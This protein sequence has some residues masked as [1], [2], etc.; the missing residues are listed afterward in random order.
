MLRS[1]FPITIRRLGFSASSCA[2]GRCGSDCITTGISL[3]H[4]FS[5]LAGQRVGAFGTFLFLRFLSVFIILFRSTVSI[6]T[7]RRFRLQA[8]TFLSFRHN[9]FRFYSP[10][11]IGRS[12]GWWFQ[13]QRAFVQIYRRCPRDF[14]QIVAQRFV[15][16]AD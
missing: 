16:G 5:L 13:H 11:E 6:G 9:F 1:T 15:L 7:R 4:R 8:P 14:V 12:E 2:L 10:V 3:W